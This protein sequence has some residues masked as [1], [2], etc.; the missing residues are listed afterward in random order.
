MG[1][2]VTRSFPLPARLAGLGPP[3]AWSTLTSLATSWGSRFQTTQMLMPTNYDPTLDSDISMSTRNRRLVSSEHLKTDTSENQTPTV[4]TVPTA[5]RGPGPSQLMTTPPSSC[6][7]QTPESRL[8]SFICSTVH[9]SSK[10][11][12]LHP[13]HL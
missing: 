13:Q 3:H 12:G 6:L 11:C 4:P 7:D 8:L 9:G 5:L 1:C 2:L 10:F